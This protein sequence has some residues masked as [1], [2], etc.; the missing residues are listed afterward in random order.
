MALP[1]RAESLLLGVLSALRIGYDLPLIHE[2][3]TLAMDGPH[4]ACGANVST[5]P[6]ES[7]TPLLR[8][9]EN[10]NYEYVENFLKLGA[11]IGYENARGETALS[12]AIKI[13]NHQ[14]VVFLIERGAS[15]QYVNK[16]DETSLTHYLRCSTTPDSIE[17]VLKQHEPPPVRPSDVI[18]AIIQGRHRVL[19]MLLDHDSNESKAEVKNDLIE[20]VGIATLL[21][22]IDFTSGRTPLMTAASAGRSGTV[23]LLLA[24][25]AQADLESPSGGHTALTISSFF[26]HNDTV[27]ALINNGEAGIDYETNTGQT[28][29]IQ[30]CVS[31]K[32]DTARVLLLAGADPN[33]QTRKQSET[34]LTTASRCGHAKVVMALLTA[35]AKINMETRSGRTALSE[36]LRKNHPDVVKT[37]LLD[38]G[39]SLNHIPNSDSEQKTPLMQAVSFGSVEALNVLLTKVVPKDINQIGVDLYFEN[40]VKQT[41]LGTA[42]IYGQSEA[43]LS[44]IEAM[45]QHTRWLNGQDGVEFNQSILT[46]RM[47]LSKFQRYHKRAKVHAQELVGRREIAAICQNAQGVTETMSSGIKICELYMEECIDA[48]Q[49]AINS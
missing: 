24:R 25:G 1:T 18:E 21:D 28:A 12:E 10:T 41:A 30:T 29:L 17:W 39:I 16:Y 32:A 5:E 11:S 7:K 46:S 15:L 13:G 34:A 49:A 6:P 40:N 47:L 48:H 14:M 37:L 31:G 35:G 26:G 9:V 45:V 42:I 27:R 20:N 36:A 43:A 38:I 33:L 3:L 4:P 23:V 2:K 19:C 44:V 22:G 8:A